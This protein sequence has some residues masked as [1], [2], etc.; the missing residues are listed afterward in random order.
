MGTKDGIVTS[1]K[2]NIAYLSYLSKIVNGLPEALQNAI[3][4]YNNLENKTTTVTIGDYAFDERQDDNVIVSI[5]KYS[6]R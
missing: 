2:E 5:I 1:R 4:R 6:N 3:K